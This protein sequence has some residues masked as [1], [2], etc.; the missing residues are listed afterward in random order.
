MSFADTNERLAAN[1]KI[2]ERADKHIAVA[3]LPT[4][5]ATLSYT[6]STANH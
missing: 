2:S 1:L 5:Q 6:L 4:G 3:Q